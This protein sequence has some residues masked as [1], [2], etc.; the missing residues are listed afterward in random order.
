MKF[1]K[2]NSFFRFNSLDILSRI[3][4]KFTNDLCK[5]EVK[6]ASQEEVKHDLEW[7]I[8]ELET[9]TALEQLFKTHENDLNEMMT[10]HENLK[11]TIEKVRTKPSENSNSND[12]DKLT[13]IIKQLNNRWKN[14]VQTYI[15]R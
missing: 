6:L 14:A 15:E 1:L 8:K 2:L 9:L 4:D 10:L 5:I 12:I 13:V 11:Q 7:I 3:I